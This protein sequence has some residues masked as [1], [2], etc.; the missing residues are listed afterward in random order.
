[1]AVCPRI[2]SHAWPVDENSIL[3]TCDR[4]RKRKTRFSHFHQTQLSLVKILSYLT[5]VI[6]YGF[7]THI[8]RHIQ[9]LKHQSHVLI[10][11]LCYYTSKWRVD[12]S[13]Y[14][15]FYSTRALSILSFLVLCWWLLHLDLVLT[16]MYLWVCNFPKKM[17][18]A[19]VMILVLSLLSNKEMCLTDS[20]SCTS[21]IPLNQ[22][23]SSRLELPYW[24]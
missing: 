23:I 22:Q 2:R 3:D 14:I 24:W 16:T 8:I 20:G 18:S 13:R 5:N 21:Y 10:V 15:F 19:R 12:M 4:Y 17:G 9:Y 1:M 11:K 6:C 7:L